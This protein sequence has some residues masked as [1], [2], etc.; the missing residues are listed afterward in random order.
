MRTQTSRFQF[1]ILGAVA[2][3]A[4]VMFTGCATEQ[5][6][7]DE[8]SADQTVNASA[9]TRIGMASPKAEWD[10]RLAQVGSIDARRLYDDLASVDATVAIART[11]IAAHRRPVLSFK[12]PGNDWAGAA[13]GR[14]DT[15]IRALA[16]QLAALPGRVF[17]AIH[18]EPQGD[19][20]PAQYA[21][22]QRHVLPLLS[23]P[24]NV[25]AGVIVNGFW[26]SAM[27]QGL[28]DTEIAQWLPADVLRLSEIVACDTYQG[29]TTDAPGENAGVKITRFSAWA[30]R[31]GVTR[32][33]IGEYNGLNAAAITAAGNA[34]LAD[35]HFVFA[36]IF[37]SSANNRPGVDWTLTGSRLTAFQATVTAARLHN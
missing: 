31:V 26:W 9:F 30:A 21:A 33:G 7:P 16:T 12:I 6:A 28:N 32:L 25:D 24:S 3:A 4:S 1:D 15:Q 10:M 11:E 2:L 29:G 14:Y 34:I 36:C 18:H 17:V 19:G 37:N 13:A 8:D 27:G 5:A 35:H 20:T 23:P 22:M